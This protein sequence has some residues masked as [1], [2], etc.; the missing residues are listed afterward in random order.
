VVAIVDRH[1]VRWYNVA[2]DKSSASA[3]AKAEAAAL[4][5]VQSLV[6]RLSKQR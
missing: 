6:A 2:Y 4:A 5:E 3:L 1:F